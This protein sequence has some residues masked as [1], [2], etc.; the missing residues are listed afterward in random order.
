MHRY[1]YQRLQLQGKVMKSTVCY[2]ALDVK[3]LMISVAAALQQKEPDKEMAMTSHFDRDD[4]LYLRATV[5]AVLQSKVIDIEIMG[6]EARTSNNGWSGPM[7]SGDWVRLQ[8]ASAVDDRKPGDE[9]RLREFG[10]RTGGFL[11]KAEGYDWEWNDASC[12]FEGV[13]NHKEALLT[14]LGVDNSAAADE[15]LE[16]RD[17]ANALKQFLDEYLAE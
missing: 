12:P 9:Q 15:I 1:F 14:I 5:P 10:K 3:T 6:Y 16:D 17:V 11:L 7:S 4:G 2:P 13:N 8:T